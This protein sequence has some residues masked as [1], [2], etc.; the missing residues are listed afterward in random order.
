MNF[1]EIHQAQYEETVT[2]TNSRIDELLKTVDDKKKIIKTKK[3][4]SSF[5]ESK[6]RDSEKKLA[7]KPWNTM[8]ADE[9]DFDRE[10]SHVSAEFIAVKIK[11]TIIFSDPDKFIDEKQPWIDS[12]ALKIKSKF[13]VNASLFPNEKVRIGYVQNLIDE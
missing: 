6:I 11:K 3:T 8:K 9:E 1:H 5:M 12:W 10:S 2:E 7:K 13:R 4:I